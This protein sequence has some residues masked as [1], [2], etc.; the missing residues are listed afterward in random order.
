MFQLV[1][2]FLYYISVWMLVYPTQVLP[3]EV[4]ILIFQ[5]LIDIMRLWLGTDW[6][7]SFSFLIHIMYLFRYYCVMSYARYQG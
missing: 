3:W 4:A 2:C 5:S 1:V 6:I 7:F